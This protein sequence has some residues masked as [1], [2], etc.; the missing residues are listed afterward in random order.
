MKEFEDGETW[1]EVAFWKLTKRERHFVSEGLLGYC[2]EHEILYCK[3]A[4]PRCVVDMV[5]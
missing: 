1:R 2:R 3:E 4:M 5:F